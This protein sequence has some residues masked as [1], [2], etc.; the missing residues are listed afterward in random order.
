MHLKFFRS[1]DGKYGEVSDIGSSV[2]L[3]YLR[4]VNER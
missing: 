1:A 2:V 3:V 4:R